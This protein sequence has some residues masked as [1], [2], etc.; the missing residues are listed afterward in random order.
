[1]IAPEH[2]ATIAGDGWSK[3][4]VRR[5]VWEHCEVSVDGTRAPKFREPACLH[6]VVAGG[7]AGRF[8]AWVPGWPFRGSPSRMVLKPV[9]PPGYNRYVPLAD[10]A[11]FRLLFEANPLPMWVYDVGTLAFLEVNHA[12]VQ[13]YGYT[14]EEF[15]RMK[16]TALFPPE[17]EARVREAVARLPETAQPTLRHY[18]ATWKHRLKDGRVIDVDIVA[19]DLS[20]DGR[21]AALVVANDVTS[22]KAAQASLAKSTQRLRVLHEI[23]RGMIAAAEPVQIAEAALRPLRDL[24]GVPRAIVNLF[25]L[26][27][28]EVEWLA[29]IG[30]RRVRVGP[31]V[32]YPLKLAGDVEA[33][34]RGEMQL[35]DVDA[36]PDS[37]AR[38]RFVNLVPFLVHHMAVDCLRLHRRKCSQADMQ[39]QITHPHAGAPDLLQ[40]PIREMQPGRRGRH[41]SR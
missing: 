20:F 26:E 32:R 34:R 35:I 33:L 29:A 14:R 30:R 15:L 37:P 38:R 8:S 39:R 40:H 19:H 5:F 9:A 16:V 24:L 27:A 3:S 13:H 4:D 36:L 2:A 23:D 17:E 18:D 6:V 28:G 1:V 11:S 41:R 21:R 25:D 31:G 22:L 7:T 10:D 12:T